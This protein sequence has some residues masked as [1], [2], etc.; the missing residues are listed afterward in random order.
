MTKEMKY[1]IRNEVNAIMSKLKK[2]IAQGY[3]EFHH[4]YRYNHEIV[5]DIYIDTYW[6]NTFICINKFNSC[7]PY[8]FPYDPES[9]LFSFWIKTQ[10]TCPTFYENSEVK[11]TNPY[12]FFGMSSDL[13]E[14]R[15]VLKCVFEFLHCEGEENI[16]DEYMLKQLEIDSDWED[17]YH[18][19]VDN[20]YEVRSYLEDFDKAEKLWDEK[21]TNIRKE[22][23]WNAIRDKNMRK[24]LMKQLNELSGAL[25]VYCIDK[26]AY[27]LSSIEG[28]M[29]YDIYEKCQC[30]IKFIRERQQTEYMRIDDYRWSYNHNIHFCMGAYKINLPKYFAAD[31]SERYGVKLLCTDN[32]YGD[33]FCGV[34]CHSAKQLL[35]I[36]IMIWTDIVF[37]ELNG[38]K[39]YF[40]QQ[41]E[42][43]KSFDETLR[44]GAVD[45]YHYMFAK[46]AALQ[47]AI[48][49]DSQYASSFILN[50][51]TT[52][53]TD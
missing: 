12:A 16:K 42:F 7:E 52:E 9:K 21:L 4:A 50:S 43:D 27:V 23:L 18:Y 22:R 17:Y 35:Y 15:N 36:T 8:R 38:A 34:Y 49:Q 11:H 26:A 37:R 25:P 10:G 48:A 53:T 47:E 39:K 33:E 28:V 31:I 5:I 19:D 41:K 6:D 51:T 13:K 20:K 45:C 30:L 2:R 1:M 40:K 24:V 14:V 46:C 32:S 3:E 29:L 44:K